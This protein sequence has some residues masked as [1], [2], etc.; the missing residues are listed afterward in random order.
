[1]NF[2]FLY[3]LDNTA[4]SPAII[5]ITG[6]EPA[7][8]YCPEKVYYVTDYSDSPDYF[9]MSES[10]KPYFEAYLHD[11]QLESLIGR[12]FKIDFEIVGYDPENEDDYFDIQDD[13]DLAA[14]LY[15]ITEVDSF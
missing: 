3:G 14:D 6:I 4:G 2:W 15:S 7:D 12:Y 5:K 1:M 11:N 9:L 13:E 10:A 8:E